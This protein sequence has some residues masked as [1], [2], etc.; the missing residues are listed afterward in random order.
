VS[1]RC[2]S[3]C[4]GAEP[5]A[6]KTSSGKLA[7]RDSCAADPPSVDEEIRNADLP[8]AKQ[9]TPRD[10]T[11]LFRTVDGEPLILCSWAY[12]TVSGNLSV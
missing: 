5:L 9:P 1:C 4:W 2:F 8:A 11:H 3:L 12:S 6:L 7:L 10:L